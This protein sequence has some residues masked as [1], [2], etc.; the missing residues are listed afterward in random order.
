MNAENEFFSVV[1]HFGP[2]LQ[3]YLGAKIV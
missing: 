3:K 1:N 2:S